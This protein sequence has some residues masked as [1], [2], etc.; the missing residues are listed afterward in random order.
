MS[1]DTYKHNRL[2]PCPEMVCGSENLAA[3][4]VIRAGHAHVGLRC[5]HCG[6]RLNAEGAE[7]FRVL[8]D[9]FANWNNQIRRFVS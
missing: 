7:P 2:L 5:R 3:Q 4:I 9:A 6:F 8:A 1:A